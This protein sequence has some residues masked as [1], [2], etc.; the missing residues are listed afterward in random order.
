M[1][2]D[3]GEMADAFLIDEYGGVMGAFDADAAK[4][5]ERLFG[6]PQVDAADALTASLLLGCNLD[7]TRTTVGEALSHA[8]TASFSTTPDSVQHLLLAALEHS[9]PNE[10]L[11]EATVSLLKFLR[12][13][14]A[15]GLTAPELARLR[16]IREL[17]P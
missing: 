10:S 1:K 12:A 2:M 16:R 6:P 13:V 9:G 17:H 5:R 15:T 3:V 4:E 14:L 7:C 11:G 8:Q